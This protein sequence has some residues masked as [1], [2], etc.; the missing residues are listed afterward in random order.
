MKS[1]NKSRVFGYVMV[2]LGEGKVH[3]AGYCERCDAGE[4]IFEYCPVQQDAE[5]KATPRMWELCAAGFHL[6]AMLACEAGSEKPSLYAHE[7]CSLYMKVIF[8]KHY[9]AIMKLATENIT[10]DI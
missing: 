2:W 6:L 8:V 10:N 3:E 7:S 5:A 9:E 1:R 4:V